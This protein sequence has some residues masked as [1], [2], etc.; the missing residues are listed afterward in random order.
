[1]QDSSE[2]AE[3]EGDLLERPTLRKAVEE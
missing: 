3:T 1:V 2:S